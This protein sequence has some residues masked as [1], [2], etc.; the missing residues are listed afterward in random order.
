[1]FEPDRAP[2]GY[3]C[4]I[5]AGGDFHPALR[6][7]VKKTMRRVY[8]TTLAFYKHILPLH[9]AITGQQ[10]AEKLRA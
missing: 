3:A 10:H 2:A 9:F 1:M 8:V 5:T 6:I 7:I 4:A